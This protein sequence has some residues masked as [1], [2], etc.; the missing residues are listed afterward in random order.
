MGGGGYI[1]VGGLII[2][3]IVLYLYSSGV[4][5]SDVNNGV[6]GSSLNIGSL[7]SGSLGTGSLVVTAPPPPPVPAVNRF[8]ALSADYP[9][10]PYHFGPTCDSS[11]V[12]AKDTDMSQRVTKKACKL[13]GEY[14][15]KYDGVNENKIPYGDDIEVNCYNVRMCRNKPAD[16]DIFIGKYQPTNPLM[17]GTFDKDNVLFPNALCDQFGGVLRSGRA[18]ASNQCK[19]GLYKKKDLPDDMYIMPGATGKTLPGLRKGM[20]SQSYNLPMGEC[21]MMGG[22]WNGGTA[23]RT[24]DS[25]VDCHFDWYTN[26]P[27]S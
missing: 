3:G 1:A 16:A 2:V 5:P 21:R 9:D 15:A 25:P 24:D 14:D 27:S 26:A 23:G 19:V 17:L 4:K 8:A 7:N 18:Y 6:G 12:A 20:Y 11:R 13:I 10:G 22:G